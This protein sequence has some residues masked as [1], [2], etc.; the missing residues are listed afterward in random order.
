MPRSILNISVG[1]HEHEHEPHGHEPGG[2]ES[3]S[4][5]HATVPAHTH[6][7]HVT[8][9]AGEAVTQ[10]AAGYIQ[11]DGATSSW[12]LVV[13]GDGRLRVQKKTGVGWE[14]RCVVI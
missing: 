14:T 1:S 9:G 3:H 12:R 2:E 7:T 4:H 10:L 8:M 6:H 11:V 5:E 13:E